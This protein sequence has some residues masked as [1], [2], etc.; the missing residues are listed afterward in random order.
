MAVFLSPAEN[1]S[2]VNWSLLD[3]SVPQSGPL[4]QKNRSTYFIFFNYGFVS[5]PEFIFNVTIYDPLGSADTVPRLDV[6][7]VTQYLF[8]QDDREE[9]FTKFIDS[10]PDF[11][12]V[13][14]W[15]STY[16]SWKF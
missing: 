5:S 9:G 16:E 1:M 10:F 2:L 4:W 8:H 6:A 13:Q 7:F 3:G 12:Y 14:A 11:V 15:M